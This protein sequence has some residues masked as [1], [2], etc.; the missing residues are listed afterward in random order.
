M[1]TEGNQNNNFKFMSSKISK[2]EFSRTIRERRTREGD[3]RQNLDNDDQD[4]EGKY[5]EDGEQPEEETEE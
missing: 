1:N 2:A 3:G 4:A 5:V